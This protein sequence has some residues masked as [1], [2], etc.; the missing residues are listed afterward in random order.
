MAYDEDL[1]D[2]V[3]EHLLGEPGL[4]EKRMFGGLGF[5]IG[6][7]LTV[8]VSSRGGLLLRIDPADTARLLDEPHTEPFEMRGRELDGWLRVDEAVLSSE[9]DLERWVGHGVRY[10]RSL[11]AKP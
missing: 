11:P 9:A 10:A 7:H 2:R 6:G 5:L 8:S 3:R 1:A 4:T